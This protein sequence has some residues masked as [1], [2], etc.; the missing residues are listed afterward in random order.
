MGLPS[1]LQDVNPSIMVKFEVDR[2]DLSFEYI[3]QNDLKNIT[4]G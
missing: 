1:E 3:A 4:V 2:E